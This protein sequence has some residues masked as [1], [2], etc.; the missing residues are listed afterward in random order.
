MRGNAWKQDLAQIGAPPGA[1]LAPCCAKPSDN[2]A[3]GAPPDQTNDNK[4][5]SPESCTAP[6][7]WHAPIHALA[8]PEHPNAMQKQV[9][10]E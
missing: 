6:L 2:R 5:Q 9:S 7:D 8:V 10:Q 1:N 4:D 3:R